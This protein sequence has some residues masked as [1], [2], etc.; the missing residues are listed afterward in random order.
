MAIRGVWE[1]NISALLQES[2]A[3]PKP[4]A[5]FKAQANPHSLG[6]GLVEMRE[7]HRAA[8]SDALL[9]PLQMLCCEWTTASRLRQVLSIASVLIL[10]DCGPQGIRRNVSKH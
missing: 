10:A 5:P 2:P 7:N 4:N 1:K 9:A 3:C 6:P 8:A